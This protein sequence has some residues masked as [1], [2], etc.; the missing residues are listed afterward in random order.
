MKDRK[1]AEASSS[2]GDREQPMRQK[3]ADALPEI[4]CVTIH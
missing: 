2:L 1:S 3:E 4:Y